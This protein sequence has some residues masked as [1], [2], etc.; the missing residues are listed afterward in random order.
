M[1]KF[2]LWAI[3]GLIVNSFALLGGIGYGF[4]RT[5]HFTAL[6]LET[7][8]CSAIGIYCSV[9]ILKRNSMGFSLARRQVWFVA[10]HEAVALLYIHKTEISLRAV[11]AIG[12]IA[13]AALLFKLFSSP[14]AKQFSRQ[15]AIKAQG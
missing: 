11:A 10:A 6:S 4:A 2:R 14:E 8:I 1:K 5:P 3:F 9:L 7:I 15:G 12:A 13:S